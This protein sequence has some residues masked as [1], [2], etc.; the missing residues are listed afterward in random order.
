MDTKSDLSKCIIIIVTVVGCHQ[1]SKQH[2]QWAFTP[3]Q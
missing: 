3:S 1:P 2:V